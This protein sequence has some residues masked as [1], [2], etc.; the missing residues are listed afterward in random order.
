MRGRIT[1][2][3]IVT[4]ENAL[5]AGLATLAAV[6]LYL[7]KRNRAASD[8]HQQTIDELRDDH[9]E[10]IDAI[11]ADHRAERDALCNTHRTERDEIRQ[12]NAAISKQF[13]VVLMRLAGMPEDEEA[14]NSSR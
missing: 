7:E 8:T 13:T 6:I 3:L 1:K 12:Q 10:R 4:L 5:L 9:K 14:Q 11:I 2:G